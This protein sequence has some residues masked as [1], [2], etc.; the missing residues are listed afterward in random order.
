MT[1]LLLAI[2]AILYALAWLI[3]RAV[4]AKMETTE[5]ATGTEALS[6]GLALGAVL[7]IVATA[8]LAFA[9]FGAFA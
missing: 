2:A 6:V 9:A 3:I 8:L 1:A 4:K 5:T 7:A